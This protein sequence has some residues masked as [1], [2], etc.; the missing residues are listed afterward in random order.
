[1]HMY[2]IIGTQKDYPAESVFQETSSPTL[3]SLIHIPSG[4]LHYMYICTRFA[5]FVVAIKS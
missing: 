1:M 5:G 2:I 4:M 3:L